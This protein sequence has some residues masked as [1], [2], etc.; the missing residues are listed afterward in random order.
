M[1]IPE[2]DAGSKKSGVSIDV[3]K[4]FVALLGFI[5][6]IAIGYVGSSS[7]IFLLSPTDSQSNL[8][9]KSF[10]SMPPN[11]VFVLVDD[12]GY[13]SL[14]KNVAPF[15]TG[16]RDDGITLGNYYTLEVCTPARAALLT[17]RYPLL[18]GW[19]YS[20][21]VTDQPTGLNLAETTFVEVLKEGL[22]STYMFGK[23]NLGNMSP[24]YLPTAR[25]FDIFVGFLGGYNNYW[26][27]TDPSNDA[28]TDFMMATPVCYYNYD[29]ADLKTYSTRLYKEKAVNVITEHDFSET[30]LFM[31]L[32]FQA[33]HSPFIDTADDTYSDGIPSDYLDS[34]VYDY[35]TKNVEGRVQQEYYKSLA[36]LD[37]S[38]KDIYQAM[39]DAGALDNSYIIFASDNGG[40]PTAGGRNG[41]LRG[42]KGSLFEGGSKV[43]AFVYSKKFNDENRGTSYN[44][45]FHVSDWF[46]TIL[47]MAGITYTPE[48]GYE[49]SGYDQFSSMTSIKGDDSPRTEML[50][51]YYYNPAD[52]NAD[53]ETV[54]NSVP[55]A[56]RTSQYKL[57]HT[58]D[59]S[60]AGGYYSVDYTYD[61]DDA[62]VQEFM[63]CTQEAAQ[64]GTFTYY[65]FDLVN[66]PYETTNLYDSS[67]EIKAVQTKLY[68]QLSGYEESASAIKRVTTDSA[69]AKM[70]KNSNYYEIPW[71]DAE[72]KEDLPDFKQKSTYPDYCGSYRDEYAGVYQLANGSY[73]LEPLRRLRR[74][75]LV[76]IA[77][78]P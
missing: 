10:A 38:V 33:V 22:Y 7:N 39:N 54:W 51:N 40:C 20:E 29:D 58:Y 57:M 44:G 74:R 6:V 59:S 70:W 25:G 4:G 27:K 1:T 43:D 64:T 68:D 24:R 50:Y 66:D 26:S 5:A 11:I 61:N 73:A 69:A 13:G 17:G 75:G 72:A 34:D 2:A 56:V 77:A 62:L 65:L 36:V 12:L 60:T 14:D 78:Q 48:E 49:L 63:G 71:E 18:M 52:P 23:W 8:L 28:F 3:V 47:T 55:M 45:L 76:S 21:A 67:D 31:Y 9:K 42:T 32:A 53:T 41:D 30:S 37:D 16:L 15:L 35:I 46:P 19:Q